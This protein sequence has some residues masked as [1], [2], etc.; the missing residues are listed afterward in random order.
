LIDLGSTFFPP[1]SPRLFPSSSF[2]THFFADPLFSLCKHFF[3]EF[4]ANF[5]RPHASLRVPRVP[6]PIAEV[7]I[8]SRTSR[9]TVPQPPPLLVCTF[10]SGLIGV[11]H[12]IRSRPHFPQ[13]M[14]FHFAGRSLS[15]CRLTLMRLSPAIN[16]PFRFPEELL[17]PNIWVMLSESGQSDGLSRFG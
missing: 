2:N 9:R 17:P 14:S 13:F 1:I 4:Y 11:F 10:I 6:G 8:V 7:S 3:S 16:L 15:L 12:F 5:P